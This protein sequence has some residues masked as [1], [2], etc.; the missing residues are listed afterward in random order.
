MPGTPEPK[1]TTAVTAS[2]LAAIE[3]DLRDFAAKLQSAAKVAKTQPNETDFG[4]FLN[5]GRS[6]M[7]LVQP[8]RK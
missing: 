7:S 5:L 1:T 8:S 4:R 3:S 6:K 2:Q